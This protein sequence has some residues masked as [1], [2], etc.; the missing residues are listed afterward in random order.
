[1]HRCKKLSSSASAAVYLIDQ[2]FDADFLLLIF[3]VH[4]PERFIVKVS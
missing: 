1:M 4:K 2:L 3:H